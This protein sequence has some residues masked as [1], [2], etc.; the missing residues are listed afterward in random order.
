M[1]LKAYRVTIDDSRREAV[2]FGDREAWLSDLPSS[3]QRRASPDLHDARNTN[4]A[5]PHAPD[6]VSCQMSVCGEHTH[7]VPALRV[8]DVAYARPDPT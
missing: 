5:K 3:P 8:V 2:V 1:T 7:P 6:V 4:R